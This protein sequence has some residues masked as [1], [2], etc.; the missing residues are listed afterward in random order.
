M[1]NTIQIKRSATTA[2]PATLAVGELAFSEL[3]GNLFI[4]KTGAVVQKIAGEAEISKLSGIEAGAQVNT[5]TSVAS[6]TGAVT[7]TATDVGLGN[8]TNESKATMFTDPTFTG[9]VS[10]V[11]ATHVGL[12]NVDNTSDANKPVST[13]Q[14]TAI[15]LKVSKAGDTMTG[16]LVLSGDPTSALHAA[17]KQYVDATSIGLDWKQ[18]VRAASTVDYNLPQTGTFTLDGV[19]L[20]AGDRFLLK[21]QASAAKNGIWVCQTGDWTRPA[22]WATG[23]VSAGA[24]MYVE[25]GTVNSGSTWIM[26]TTG[27]ITVGT[28]SIAFVQFGGGATYTA[29][30]GLQLI[31][32]AFSIDSS[33]LT[34]GST[35]DVTKFGTGIAA[36]HNG[37]LITDLNGSNIATGTVAD[38]RLSSAVLLNTSTIDGGSF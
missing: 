30:T 7:L 13:A 29:S 33:V 17:T 19:S 4:G 16:A 36:A 6:R 35:L 23:T 21:N 32:S 28:T 15:G 14:A 22:D 25:G 9:T 5:V 3:S 1:A 27:T 20:A 31:G 24:V 11:T 10:G 38:A 8:V 2:T 26:N 37:S 18:S 12:G 34:T